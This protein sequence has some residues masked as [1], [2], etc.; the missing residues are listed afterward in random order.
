MPSPVGKNDGEKIPPWVGRQAAHLVV[1][2]AQKD[3]VAN[4]DLQRLTDWC[5]W[6]G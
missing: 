2:F 6:H 3:R 5:L 4:M 1:S